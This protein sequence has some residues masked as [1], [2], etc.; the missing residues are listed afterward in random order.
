VPGSYSKV[1]LIVYFHQPRSAVFLHIE[2]HLGPSMVLVF[3]DSVYS[4]NCDMLKTV[5]YFNYLSLVL[6]ALSPEILP[7]NCVRPIYSSPS[8]PLFSFQAPEHFGGWKV[9][10]HVHMS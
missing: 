6:S 10:R 1:S 4:R 5:A 7:S 3:T 2:S 9:E 8:S